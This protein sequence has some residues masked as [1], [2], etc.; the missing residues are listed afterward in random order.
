MNKTIKSLLLLAGGIFLFSLAT[1]LFL[2]PNDIV[3]GGFSGLA[4][5]VNDLTGMSTSLFYFI[6]NIFLLILALIFLGRGYVFKTLAGAIIFYPVFLAIIPVVQLTTDPLINVVVS[7]VLFGFG[8]VLIYHSGGSGGGTVILGNIVHKFSNVSFG[9]SVAIFDLIIMITGFYVFGFE[10]SM[11]GVFII[12][13]GT[14]ITNYGI[15]GFKKLNQVQVISTK[16]LEIT[17]RLNDELNRG[18]TLLNGEGGYTGENKKVVM[19]VVNNTELRRVK[20]IIAEE[21]ENAFVIVSQVS[22]TY[23][24][25]FEILIP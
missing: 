14:F 9:V 8:T 10:K 3:A 24:E 12:L 25:G 21:D 19:C 23:G 15:T 17:K 4:I 5:V 16:P 22:T 20:E 18:V 6:S 7:G 1:N 2:Q 13:L 11:Y